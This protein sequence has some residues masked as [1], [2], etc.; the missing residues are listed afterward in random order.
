M[1]RQV[2]ALDG[3][4]HEGEGHQVFQTDDDRL[5]FQRVATF[6]LVG[7]VLHALVAGPQNV[8]PTPNEA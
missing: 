1:Q 6:R 8:H 7:N 4:P 3:I 2:L 5:T